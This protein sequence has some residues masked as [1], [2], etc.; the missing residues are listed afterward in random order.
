M[1]KKL[2]LHSGEKTLRELAVT[3]RQFSL[4]PRFDIA[5]G[6]LLGA[7]VEIDG[8]RVFRGFRWGLV[9]SWWHESQRERQR[10]FAA[11]AETLAQRPAFAAALQ[12]RRA[13]VPADGFWMWRDIEGDR[14]PF[15]FRARKG[16]PLWLAAIWD[17]GEAGAEDRLALVSVE[18]NRLVEPLGARM[19]AILRGDAARMWLNSSLRAEKPLLKSLGTV[20]S[21]FLTVAATDPFA[22]GFSSLDAAPNSRELLSL[23]YGGSFRLDKPRFAPRKRLVRRDHAASGQVF[24]RTRSFTRDDATRWH[25][26][27]DVE[28]GHVF[29]DCPD[30][31]YR[32][33]HNEPDVWTPN[34]WCKHVARAVENCRRHGELPQRI[35]A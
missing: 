13:L 7:V 17:E 28:S 25:P 3:R 33:A 1:Q 34:W 19:P 9:P 6:Q 14:V 31:R 26:V 23:T 18:S 10:L 29:C 12:G 22:I 16:E 35:A 4:S 15:Y 24:F 11:R 27:V 30:F 8:E 21:R 2:T 5:P 20:P 32:H